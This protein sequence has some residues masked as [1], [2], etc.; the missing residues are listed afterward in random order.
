MNSIAERLKAAREAAGLTQPQLATKARVSQGTIGNIE[1]GLRKRPRDLLSIASALNV[2][3][4]W[5]ESGKGPMHGPLPDA[6]AETESPFVEIRRAG[7][8]FSNGHGAVAYYEDDKPPLSFRKDFL[9]RL[10]IPPGKAVVVDATGISNE[11]KI[12]DG[13]VVL[14]NTAAAD[15][16]NGEFFAFRADGELL[17]KRLEPLDGIG[18]LATAENPNFKPKTRIYREGVD[19]W[20]VIG[21]AV[22]AGSML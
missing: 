5:L 4:V 7:V 12:P 2:S 8:K 1:S 11:P 10:G 9:R 15:R 19:D 20:E 21:Q 13:A 22:W 3:P 17:I 14:V 6:P 16:L 18:V